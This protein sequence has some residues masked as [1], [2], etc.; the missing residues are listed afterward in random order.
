M[1]GRERDWRQK[2]TRT[3]G[4][5]E[6]RRDRREVKDRDR[7]A[8]TEGKGETETETKAESRLF[9]DSTF[10]EHLAIAGAARGTDQCKWTQMVGTKI[11][12]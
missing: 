12:Q 8:E 7:E 9:I 10:I 1:R 2:N 5:D 3:L 4:N 6:R 11:Q